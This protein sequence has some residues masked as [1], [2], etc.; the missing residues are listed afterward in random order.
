MNKFI[1]KYL[2]DGKW[3]CSAAARS[4]ENEKK[5]II[6]KLR[7]QQVKQCLTTCWKSRIESHLFDLN[8]KW[9]GPFGVRMQ[10][11]DFSFFILNCSLFFAVAIAL[12]YFFLLFALIWFMRTLYQF[13]RLIG[14]QEQQKKCLPHLINNCGNLIQFNWNQTFPSLRWNVFFWVLRK[15]VHFSRKVVEGAE[16]KWRSKRKRKKTHQNYEIEK[17]WDSCMQFSRENFKANYI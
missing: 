13:L 7:G 10:H 15:K 16:K 11:T 1:K 4:E 6:Q 5:K 8:E 14:D 9:F 2:I 17:S 3:S 12:V